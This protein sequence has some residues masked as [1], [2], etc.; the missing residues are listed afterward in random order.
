[1]AKAWCLFI[2]TAVSS[3][4]SVKGY[5]CFP[6]PSFLESYRHLGRQ[7][8]SSNY[9]NIHIIKYIDLPLLDSIMLLKRNDSSA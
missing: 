3:V 9:A 2:T 6:I 1:M 5:T 4:F 8:E 7:V